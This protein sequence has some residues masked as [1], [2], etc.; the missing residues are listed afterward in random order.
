MVY[1]GVRLPGAHMDEMEPK[2]A[3]VM[4]PLDL[5]VVREWSVWGW[6]VGVLGGCVFL[7]ACVGAGLL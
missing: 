6:L 7:L 4:V 1:A 2:V 5:R 3:R